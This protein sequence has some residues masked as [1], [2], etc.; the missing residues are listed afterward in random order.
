MVRLLQGAQNKGTNKALHSQVNLQA[1]N[2]L[3]QD[4]SALSL[5]KFIDK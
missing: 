3:A 4:D 1:H 2:M 5:T